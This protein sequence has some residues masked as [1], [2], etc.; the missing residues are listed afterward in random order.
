MK[1]KASAKLKSKNKENWKNNK[2]IN[3]LK[4]KPR[5][6]KESLPDNT[7]DRGLMLSSGV[8]EDSYSVVI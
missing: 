7:S 5:D 1:L 6:G 4:R 3:L 8:S 2:P